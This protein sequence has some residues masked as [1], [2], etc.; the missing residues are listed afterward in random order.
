[1]GTTLYQEQQQ[2][3][4]L[5]RVNCLWVINRNKWYDGNSYIM[6]IKNELV[7][8]CHIWAGP[9]FPDNSLTYYYFS[10]TIYIIFPS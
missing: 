5:Q 9:K 2:T 4:E 7:Q 6:R 10:L 1:M 8:G 3:L